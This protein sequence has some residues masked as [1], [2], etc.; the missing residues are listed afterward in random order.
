LAPSQPFFGIK[1]N[2][3]FRPASSP[4]SITRVTNK[5]NTSKMNTATKEVC[6]IALGWYENMDNGPD[7]IDV[8]G[9]LVREA[10]EMV[11][12]LWAENEDEM[13]PSWC[14]LVVTPAIYKT[15]DWKSIEE[16]VNEMLVDRVLGDLFD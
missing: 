13:W 7:E 12:T 10:E 11:S 4:H 15:I 5:M 3:L 1:L 16:C 9:F 2:A 6:E 14:T 8:E